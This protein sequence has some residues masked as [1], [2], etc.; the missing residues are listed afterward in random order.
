MLVVGA[1]QPIAYL[2]GIN[3]DPDNPGGHHSGCGTPGAHA[4]ACGTARTAGLSC[5]GTGRRGCGLMQPCIE[6]LPDAVFGTFLGAF[7]VE[8][9]RERR[10]DLAQLAQFGFALVASGAQMLLEGARLVGFQPVL[11]GA[12]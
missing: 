1:A 10:R 3:R 12:R 7:L 5:G 9:Q 2:A 6:A 4:A 11:L 8:T